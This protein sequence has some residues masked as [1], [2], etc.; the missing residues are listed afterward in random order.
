MRNKP[1]GLYKYIGFHRTFWTEPAVD[2]TLYFS[3]ID[4]LRSGNDEDEFKYSFHSHG[5]F[6]VRYMNGEMKR[7]YEKLMAMARVLCLSKHLDRQLWNEYCG[8][9]G[10][11]CYEFEVTDLVHDVN[12]DHVSYADNKCIN[13]PD[14]FVNETSDVH[15]PRLLTKTK[16]FSKNEL[17]YIHKW[18]N[19][20]DPEANRLSMR[21]LR[22]ELIWKKPRLLSYEN[23]FRFIHL[24]EKVQAPLQ[25][26]LVGSK[27]TWDK[28]GFRLKK[29]H[30]SDVSKT[31]SVLRIDIPI[32]P[33]EFK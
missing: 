24:V 12:N 17:A 19:T 33:I 11:V 31:K 10:G 4:E 26:Q 1:K 16:K 21:H 25:V 18:L 14:F 22:E 29:I 32:V 20:H 9:N 30:T 7:V 6:F 3:T 23:E 15:M 27:T 28:I 2:R 5:H 13:V 8:V